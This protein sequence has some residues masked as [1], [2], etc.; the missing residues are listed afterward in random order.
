VCDQVGFVSARRGSLRKGASKVV[1]K[2]LILRY[3]SVDVMILEFNFCREHF[4]Y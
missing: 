3:C 4:C 1:E 2:F